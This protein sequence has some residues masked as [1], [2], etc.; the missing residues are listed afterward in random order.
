MLICLVPGAYQHNNLRVGAKIRSK[1]GGGL[2]LY[3]LLQ[4]ALTE[5]HPR[6]LVSRS[7]SALLP[8]ECT[9]RGW[10]LRWSIFDYNVQYCVH[11]TTIHTSNGSHLPVPWVSCQGC[12]SSHSEMRSAS[13]T[14]FPESAKLLLFRKSWPHD[15]R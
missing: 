4:V 10:K 7:F 14:F 5:L 8:Q 9:I 12:S 13:S 11:H 1:G 15:S 2:R 3:L 6:E